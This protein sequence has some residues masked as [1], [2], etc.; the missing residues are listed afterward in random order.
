MASSQEITK[1]AKSNLAFALTCLP[2]QR[3]QDMVVFY[4]FCRVIDDL[5]DDPG[6]S[7]A[8][9]RAGLARWK[10]G[11][12]NGF[13]EPD[14]LET[15]VAEIIGRYS[16]SSQ[17]FLDLIDGCES[18]LAPQRF[19]TWDELKE[20]TYQVASCVGI[21][22]THIFGCTH[23]DSLKYAVALGHALQITN[24]LR[25]V[26]EDLKNGGRIY[27][28]LNDMI[29]FQYS[30]RDLI[31]RVHDGRFIAMMSYQADRAEA[32]YQE[33][34]DCLHQEDAKALKAAEAMRKIYQTLLKKI[35]AD[36]FRVFDKRYR[37]SKTRKSAI[38]IAT[39]MS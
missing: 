11:L 21:I 9:R 37:L 20:Y 15:E 4:A 2:K 34:I 18:D 27:L 14:E 30:E 35:K 25:D 12:L 28:P 31:G 19:Q 7:V 17:P 5:A 1:K 39:L 13:D 22:S 24:I 38:L 32:L 10:K 8:E 36:G 16:I 29:R 6:I 23:P 33:A 26:G 3:K